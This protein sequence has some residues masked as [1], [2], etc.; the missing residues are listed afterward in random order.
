MLYQLTKVRNE[1]GFTE[2]ELLVSVIMIATLAV[3]SISQFGIYRSRAADAR[4]KSDLRQG[5]HAQ[6][7]LYADTEH[8]AACVDALDCSEKLPGVQK[9]SPN[10][11]IQFTA[12]EP[13][14]GFIGTASSP[15]ATQIY[16]WDSLR[17]GLQ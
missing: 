12:D 16:T 11:Q 5:A 3:V 17:G 14:I 8:Y 1:K 10:T 9:F 7:S 15:S 2:V 4:V 13:D 6:H